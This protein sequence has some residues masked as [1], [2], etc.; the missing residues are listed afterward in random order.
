M[1][2]AKDDKVETIAL[3]VK[4]TELEI[5]ER[6]RELAATIGEHDA[7][8]ARQK[9]SAKR[10]KDV[11]DTHEKTIRT[12]GLVVQSGEEHRPV[13]CE[14][15]AD[16]GKRLLKLVRMDLGDVVRSRPMTDEELQEAS[17][18]AFPFFSDLGSTGG[19]TH[20]KGRRA[21]KTPDAG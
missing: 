10:L 21:S 17:Q 2:M 6:S 18:N 1:I 15:Q 19:V 9:E 11:V 7:A 4:L 5:L 3:P 16:L 20:I 13:E 8:Q 14:W 12:L